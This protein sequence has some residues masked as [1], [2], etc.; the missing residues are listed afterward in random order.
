MA[1][2][3]ARETGGSGADVCA[4]GRGAD[5]L[6]D[7]AAGA[8]EMGCG[9]PRWGAGDKAPTPP[10]Q[11][12]AAMRLRSANSAKAL[13][14]AAPGLLPDLVDA[15]N[16]TSTS[17][18]ARIA[19]THPAE[20]RGSAGAATVALAASAVVMAIQCRRMGLGGAEASIVQSERMAQGRR[21][22]RRDDT[23]AS[24][25][26]IA[27][28]V[29]PRISMSA[30][31]AKSFHAQ[32]ETAIAL[33]QVLERVEHGIEPVSADQYQLLVARLKAAL[34]VDLPE[35][36]L[37]AILVALPAAAELYENMHY[38]VSGLSRSSL[39][40][41]VASE[42]LT[43]KVLARISRDSKRG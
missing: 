2:S 15:A 3:G 5:G 20:C 23:A 21:P 9:P 13:L 39:D 27:L 42:L 10:R 6:A 30:S 1:F 11:V 25:L 43:T 31:T 41:S 7:A 18:S 4:G 12:R 38:Q 35:P 17:W 14:S 40:K 36:A 24:T 22:L 8:L 29:K 16:A 37:N 19:L 33:A 26:C 32:L 28:N 34:T